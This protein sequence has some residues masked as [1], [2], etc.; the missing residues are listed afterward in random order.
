MGLVFGTLADPF[1]NDGDLFPGERRFFRVRRGHDLVGVR[2]DHAL[3]QQAL[4]G[5][6]GNDAVAGGFAFLGQVG[7][8]VL[9]GVEAERA[10]LVLGVRAVAG[11]AVVRKN[12][13]DLGAEG[14]FLA[15]ESRGGDWR[16]GIGWCCRRGGLFFLRGIGRRLLGC[17]FARGQG[18]NQQRG[19][20]RQG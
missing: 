14:D 11:E 20:D 12:R 15:S 18:K 4:L 9:L 1:G 3:Q 5:L 2:G 19:E 8:G 13:K 16:C 10:G 6:A 7:P 17:F